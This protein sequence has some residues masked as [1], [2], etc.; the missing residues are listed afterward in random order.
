MDPGNYAPIEDEYGRP[1]RRLYS[2]RIKK[3]VRG[4]PAHTQ[5]AWLRD[6]PLERSTVLQLATHGLWRGAAARVA[7]W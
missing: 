1:V 7:A 3:R 4:A 2:G 5:T 6:G